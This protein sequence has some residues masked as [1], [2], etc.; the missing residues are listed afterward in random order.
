LVVISR[1]Q[2]T[3]RISTADPVLKLLVKIL[4]DRYRAGLVSVQENSGLEHSVSDVLLDD[5]ESDHAQRGIDKIRLEAELKQALLQRQLNVG[6]QP[7]L[8]VNHQRVAG[9]EALVRW[10]HPTRGAISPAMFIG[11]AEETSL[12]V[13]V[14]LYVFE[15]ACRDMKRFIRDLSEPHHPFMSI[16]VSLKQISDCAFLPQAAALVDKYG[17][18][19]SAIKLEITE[20]MAFDLSLIRNWVKR[21]HE[22]GFMVSLD[23]FGTG[24]S[25]LSALDI[26]MVD[27]VKLDRSFIRRIENQRARDLLSSTIE[28]VKSMDSQVVVEG[29]ETEQQLE[30]IT[31]L[32]CE[33]AQGFLIGQSLAFEDANAM[34]KTVF[35]VRDKLN[36]P[37]QT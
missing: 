25:A 23:D 28:L 11:L 15:Q 14:G 12:I 4:L 24:Y 29:V 5:A 22:Y 37:S 19:R 27:V 17:L 36:Q 21:A 10:S 30:F 32:G 16:N 8:G 7:I 9:F 1:G 18:K 35:R 34:L 2:L 33:F 13:P 31:D 3:E 20:S 26:L 6:Y